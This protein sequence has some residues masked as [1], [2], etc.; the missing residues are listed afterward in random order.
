M[1][2]GRFAVV[3]ALAAALASCGVDVAGINERPEKYYQKKVKI[4]G[5]IT[6]SQQL[7]D[8][9]LLEV[10]D[11]RG[12][13]ILVRATPPID[14]EVGDWVKVEGI[15]VPEARIGD[16]VLY[17]LVVA[18]EVSRARAPRLRGLM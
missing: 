5:H 9:L 3:A 12:A 14:A 4:S 1:R 18:D 8:A 15:L 16:V 6:R 13:R 10:A 2:L 11:E 17:D 7:P